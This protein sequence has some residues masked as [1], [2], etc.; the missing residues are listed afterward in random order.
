MQASVIDFRKVLRDAK[1]LVVEDD[2]L[3]AE[4]VAA[5]LGDLDAHVLGP[6]PRA[7]DALKFIERQKPDCVV[8]NAILQGAPAIELALRLRELQIPWVVVTAYNFEKLPP[9]LREAPCVEKP[10]KR[11]TLTT[12]VA[13]AM[14]KRKDSAAAS[15]LLPARRIE[16]D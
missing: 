8:L 16:L 12:A 4:D 2:L 11:D 1:I 9:E 13:M 7:A 6:V 3:I 10:Y 5:V 15:T 14:L